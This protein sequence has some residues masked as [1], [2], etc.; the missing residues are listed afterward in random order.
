MI[1]L[2]EVKCPRCGRVH[3]SISRE[4]A[5]ASIMRS[6]TRLA[7]QELPANFEDY[8]HCFGCGAPAWTFVPA[9][10]NDAPTGVTLTC[11]VCE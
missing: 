8:F 9:G 1:P 5:Q 2:Q 10:P 11:V 6:N 3:M 7:P 4:D